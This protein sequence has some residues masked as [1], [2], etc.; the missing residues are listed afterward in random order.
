MRITTTW[1]RRSLALLALASSLGLAIV[2]AS[3][4]NA[5]PKTGVVPLECDE[6]GSLEVVVAGTTAPST[7]G[8]AVVSTQ[9]GVPY[10]ITLSGTF[11]PVGGE[12]EP[13]LDVYE[14]RAPAHQRVDH[15]TFHEEGAT[16]SGSFVID[17]ELWISYTPTR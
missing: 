2:V 3:P 16:G 6:L 13:F 8:L 12:P 11:T 4:A 7:P 14:R 17:G 9:V 5:D 1:P 10:A 15:C